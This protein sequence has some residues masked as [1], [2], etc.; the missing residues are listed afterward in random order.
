M[1]VLPPGI[2]K[3]QTDPYGFFKLTLK[4]LQ[5]LNTAINF[6]FIKIKPIFWG[7]KQAQ[8]LLRAQN[9]A[10]DETGV[11]PHEVFY[12]VRCNVVQFYRYLRDMAKFR[13]HLVDK[14]NGKAFGMIVINLLLY[15]K[16]E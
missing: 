7:E 13:L 8:R 3:I 12:E 5:W 16:P 15:L 9:T 6:D 14:R 4:D 11:V 2:E 10:L 1:G